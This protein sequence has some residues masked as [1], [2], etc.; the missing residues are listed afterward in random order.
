MK[1]VFTSS[2]DELSSALDTR[3]GRAPKFLVYDLDTKTFEVIDNQ[4][5]LKAAFGAGIKAAK[6]VARTGASSL[7]TG[8]LH[9][10]QKAFDVLSG[11]GIKTY[12]SNA[13][14]V[15]EAL[16]QYQAGKLSQVTTAEVGEQ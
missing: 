4:D 15:A 5:N 11:A 6:K 7:V 16:A 8:Y 3:F 9:C 12:T 10:G 1:V 2:G 13:L 14:T